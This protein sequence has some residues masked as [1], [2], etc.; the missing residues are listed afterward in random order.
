MTSK[1][2]DQENPPLLQLRLWKQWSMNWTHGLATSADMLRG[3]FGGDPRCLPL[4]PVVG[5][6][7]SCKFLRLGFDKMGMVGNGVEKFG[8]LMDL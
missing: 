2:S 1:I 5:A 8:I 4:F 3:R 7:P 6:S